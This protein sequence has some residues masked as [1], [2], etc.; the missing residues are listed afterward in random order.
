[1]SAPPIFIAAFSAAC[2]LGADSA[3]IA[4][5]LFAAEPRR[6]SGVAK[7]SDG[8]AVPVGRLPFELGAAPGETRTNRILAHCYE[9]IADDVA[10]VR[11]ACGADRLGVVMGTS[12]SG[13]G[14]STAA[15]RLKLM[16]DRWPPGFSIRTHQLGEVSAFAAELAGARGPRYTVSTA[17][18]SGARAI[19]AGARL[20]RSGLCDAVLCGGVDSLCDLTLNG[21]ASLESLSD[22]P[23]N[24]MSLNRRGISIGEGGA[25]FLLTREPGAH[26]LAGWGESSDSHHVSAPDPS[27]KGAELALRKAL[28]MAGVE[29][30]EI[31]FVHLHGT[32]TRLNDAMEAGV[33]H[34]VFGADTP[35]S[36]TKPMTGHMLGA[37]GAMQAAICLMAINEGRLPPHLWDGVA[38]SDLP[39]LNL[40][41]PSARANIKMA[42]SASY[43]F[44]GNNAALILAAA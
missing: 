12:T 43:A 22:E 29:A 11:E 27:G 4:A 42:A 21:F 44:G 13:I 7:L 36:S 18:T 6:I 39:T 8:R 24:P 16:E 17:C 5:N 34:R 32:A 15:I 37:A 28:A 41:A 9:R 14:E 30:R 20:I 31:D 38:D 2:A 33:V 19:A 23:C 1:M 10:A 40:A 26:R 35:A 3:A 25:F